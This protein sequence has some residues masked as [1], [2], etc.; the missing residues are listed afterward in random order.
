MGEK[1]LKRAQNIIFPQA[2][3]QNSSSEEISDGGK[4]FRHPSEEINV[5]FL[6]QDLQ[7]A[8]NIVANVLNLIIFQFMHAENLGCILLHRE[9]VRSTVNLQ[10]QLCAFVGHIIQLSVQRPKLGIGLVLGDTAVDG[11]QE[12]NDNGCCLRKIIFEK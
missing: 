10:L 1:G 5:L 4:G 8:G 9:E 3:E 6:V 11:Q 2:E 12:E 7:V